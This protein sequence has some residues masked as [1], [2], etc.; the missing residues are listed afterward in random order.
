MFV[1]WPA[2]LVNVLNMPMHLYI[3]GSQL[4]LLGL[5]SAMLEC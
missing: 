4:S 1:G 2:G 3:N 5:E